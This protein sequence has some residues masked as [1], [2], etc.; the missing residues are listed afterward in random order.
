MKPLIASL[1]LLR[2][3]A[4]VLTRPMSLRAY[5]VL[6]IVVATIPL[7][8]F[9]LHLVER[10]AAQARGETVQSVERAGAAFALLVEREVVS[11]IDLLT[12]LAHNDALQRGDAAAFHRQLQRGMP[13][14][15]GW[16]G[17]YLAEPGGHIVLSSDQPYGTEQG[18]LRDGRALE[19]VRTTLQPAVTDLVRVAATGELVTGVQ[20]PVRVN[21]RLAYVLG[22]LIGV[23]HWQQ[24][25]ERASVP[26]GGFLALSDREFRVV[27]HR[28]E[29]GRIGHVH[30][31]L[32]IGAVRQAAADREALGLLR[33]PS[34][35]RRQA[36]RDTGWSVAAGLPAGPMLGTQAGALISLAIAGAVSLVLGLALA[37]MVARQV[38]VPLRRLASGDAGDGGDEPIVVREIATLARALRDASEQREKAL[39]ALESAHRAAEAAN[40]GKD[41]FL[42]MLGHELRNPLGAIAAAVEVLNRTQ[43][44]GSVAAS[45]R[46][47]IERQTRHMAQLMNDL[48][49]VSR[50]SAGKLTLDTRRIELAALVWRAVEALRLAGR[51]RQHVLSLDLRPTWVEADP[52]RIEQVIANLL[53]NAAKYTPSE[54]VIEVTLCRIGNDARLVVRDNGMGIAHHMLP[55]VFDLFVQGERAADRRQSGMGLGLAL[56]RRLVELQGGTV[57]AASEGPNLGSTFTVLL[58]AL[59]GDELENT[60]WSGRHAVIAA[61]A[62]ATPLD[63]AMAL[64]GAGCRVTLAVESNAA[65]QLI[66]Q[67]RP[68]IVLVD[69][70]L[71]GCAAL[72]QRA[73]DS[74]SG[75]LVVGIAADAGALAGHMFDAVLQR[76]IDL[77][78]LQRV[79][80]SRPPRPTEAQVPGE[81][82]GAAA[83]D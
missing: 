29:P 38:S 30:E 23:A 27:A 56:V 65:A 62:D 73:R 74:S 42:A 12:G 20:V 58:P 19:H 83:P 16:R 61:A 9:A 25:A 10:Q 49:D 71:P 50:A 39:G 66:A 8:L 41:E 67:S 7:A 82:A 46:Q 44:Q 79:A 70:A 33:A 22:A 55:Q 47:V 4:A 24:L 1:A 51:F 80:A 53:T 2:R 13:A 72:P 31:T 40:R 63:T 6:V 32:G 37:I 60:P 36:V 43:G 11:S 28:T 45:A 5:L 77:Q 17:V 76:P 48:Q 3:P 75:T 15:P 57:E 34:L 52:I 14:R 54:G 35:E 59:A 68:G 18:R 78:Q 21:G 26:E 69:V 81:A 64:G